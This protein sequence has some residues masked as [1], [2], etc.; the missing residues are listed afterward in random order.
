MTACPPFIGMPA[1]RELFPNV[2]KERLWRYNT[3][4]GGRYRLP[5]SDVEFG[6]RDPGWT[7]HTI[8]QWAER[9]GLKAEMDAEVLARIV[10]TND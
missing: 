8:M 5:A 3:D 9:T 7:V 10:G 2:P 4:R 6:Q 1:L